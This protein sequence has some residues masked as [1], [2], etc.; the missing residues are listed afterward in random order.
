MRACY[1][2]LLDC[3]VS[4]I[5][6]RGCTPCPRF[7]EQCVPSPT[8]TE[9]FTI[10]TYEATVSFHVSYFVF[11]LGRPRRARSR[12]GRR[13]SLHP[14]GLYGRGNMFRLLQCFRGER[15]RVQGDG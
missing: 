12:S 11:M 2:P 1:P 14:D 10:S 9:R 6:R 4:F 13:R 7:V 5:Q 8:D 3:S 15:Q